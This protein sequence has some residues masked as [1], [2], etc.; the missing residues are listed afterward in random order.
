[1][2]ASLL[3]ITQ[4]ADTQQAVYDTATR[5]ELQLTIAQ[6]VSDGASWLRTNL[7]PDVILLDLTLGDLESLD[8]IRHIRNR[9]LFN[10]IQIIVLTAYPDPRLIRRALDHGANRYLTK[11]FIN[12]NLL[13]L[14]G[15]MLPDA[16]LGNAR[17]TGRLN[18]PRTTQRLRAVR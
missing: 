5:A 10:D 12:R 18:L 13:P 2:S 8:F 11:M 14:L 7:Q 15:L 1:M 16:L 9:P 3:L 17:S 4:D 6:S